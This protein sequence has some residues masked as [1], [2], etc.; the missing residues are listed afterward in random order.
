VTFS[1]DG[2]LLAT[3]CGDKTVGIWDISSGKEVSRIENADYV[4]AVAF[5]PDGTRL[6]TATQ[7]NTARIWSLSTEDL[8]CDACNRLKCNLTSQEWQEKYCI[9]CTEFDAYPPG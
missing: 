6:A 3:N 4:V 7:W 5:S 9:K 8:I 1:P 2:T